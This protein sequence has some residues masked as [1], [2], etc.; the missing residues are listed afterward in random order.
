M[1]CLCLDPEI[2]KLLIKVAVLVYDKGLSS[3]QWGVS[4]TGHFTH[5]SVPGRR[6]RS[7]LLHML[8][9]CLPCAMT[10]HVDMPPRYSPPRECKH[11]FRAWGEPQGLVPQSC[12]TQ[13]ANKKT[14]WLNNVFLLL[15]MHV[16][17]MRL[18]IKQLQEPHSSA[19]PKLWGLQTFQALPF[20][21]NYLNGS[22]LFYCQN[23]AIAEDWNN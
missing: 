16:S 18:I 12:P 20:A 21:R 14:L 2:S 23:S 19:C 6:G 3:L 4:S 7:V 10:S 5:R 15:L 1:I 8:A 17:K 9:Q 13:Q 11:S 22:S